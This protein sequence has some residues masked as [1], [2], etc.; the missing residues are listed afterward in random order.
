MAQTRKKTSLADIAKLAGVSSAAVGKVL[1]GGGASIRVGAATRERI[2]KAAKE[3]HY[4]P[5]MAA[6][7][8]AGGSSRLIGLEL[9]PARMDAAM[10]GR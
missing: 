4:R 9:P 5:S 2:L 8:L 1:N 6:S 7:I 3:L 10:L